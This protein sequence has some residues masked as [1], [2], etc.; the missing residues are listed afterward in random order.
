[1]EA[2]SI[3]SAPPAPGIGA[4]IR[5]FVDRYGL[6]IVLLAMPVAFGIHDLI[7]DGNLVHI[8]TN[9]KDGISNGAIWALIALGYTLVYGIIELINFAH[10]DVFMIGSFISVSLFGTLGL[11]LATGTFGIVFG[12]LLTLLIAMIG[13]GTLNVMIERVAYRPLRGAP[14]LAPL[15]TAVGMS[16]ILQNV[17][18]LWKTGSHQSVVDLIGTQQHFL[19][20][21]GINITRGDVLA[22]AATAPLV[23]LL[24]TFIAKSRLGKAMRATAQDPEAARLMGINVDTTIS[25]TFLLGGM[26]A[27]AAGIIY[28]VYQTDAWFFQGFQAGLIAF[29]AAVM[30]GIGNLQGAVLGG[31]IIGFL[32]QISDDRFQATWTPAVVFA[33]L[34]LIMVFRPQGLLGE[35]GRE[36][37]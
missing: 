13:C 29:T 9:L 23:L 5:K 19:T 4:T 34:I 11:T 35:A 32:Q 16:F 12:L 3:S 15:I 8:G 37:G 24:T 17:G 21:L 2:A 25:L 26:L 14:K 10:G 18:L 6:I 22:V 36:A 7:K 27:G 30:G 33:Y 28:S 31:L 1:M 20:I